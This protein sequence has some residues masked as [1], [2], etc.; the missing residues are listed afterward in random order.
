VVRYFPVLGNF[1][2]LFAP[3]VAAYYFAI[4]GSASRKIKRPTIFL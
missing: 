1:E 3:E 4:F 2:A